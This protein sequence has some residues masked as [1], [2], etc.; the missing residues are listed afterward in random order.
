[1]K[2]EQAKERGALKKSITP[3]P[4]KKKKT[5][6]DKHFKWPQIADVVET[7]ACCTFK[8]DFEVVPVGNNARTW[9]LVC[10]CF[11]FEPNQP[12]R[13]T[14]GLN[15][16]FNL[17]PSHSFHKSLYHKSFFLKPA[18]ILSTIPGRKTRKTITH[19][20]EPIYIP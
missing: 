20:L 13:I 8:R 10:W 7:A 5:A 17:S 15:T 14:S 18:Q 19:V 12:Q 1:M 11:D 4:K 6:R 3:P 9:Q 16:N 2:N